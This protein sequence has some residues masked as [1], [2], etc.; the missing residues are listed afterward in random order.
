[1]FSVGVV[2][3]ADLAEAH[4]APTDS[5]CM[6][7]LRRRGSALAWLHS[8]GPCGKRTEPPVGC[9]ASSTFSPNVGEQSCFFLQD[10]HSSP[11]RPRRLAHRRVVVEALRRADQGDL[12]GSA[13]SP[14][15][16]ETRLVNRGVSAVWIYD[17][18]RPSHC[19]KRTGHKRTQSRASAQAAAK[20]SQLRSHCKLSPGTGEEG[21]RDDLMPVGLAQS[22]EIEPRFGLGSNSA[23]HLTGLPLER[24]CRAGLFPGTLRVPAGKRAASPPETLPRLVGPAGERQAVGRTPS[25]TRRDERKNG[26]LMEGRSRWCSGSAE[27]SR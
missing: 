6:V 24:N 2:D 16:R 27:A 18:H 4:R 12:A 13:P 9:G 14:K 26:D 20:G 21:T 5:G 19:R 17:S 11:R 15:R 1:M 3:P 7:R 25:P 22:I 8:S 23:L 10:P